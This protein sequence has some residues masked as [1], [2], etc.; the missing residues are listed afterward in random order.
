[1]MA[2]TTHSTFYWLNKTF[3]GSLTSLSLS[4]PHL[5]DKV[6]WERQGSN[7]SLDGLVL[8]LAHE[9]TKLLEM[10]STYTQ[11]SHREALEEKGQM[12]CHHRDTGSWCCMAILKLVVIEHLLCARQRWA[13][14]RT[15]D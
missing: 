8:F 14:I 12:C 13:W 5:P 15:S 7:P 3:I 1:M 9:G 2:N 10:I 4:P 11:C 6:Y